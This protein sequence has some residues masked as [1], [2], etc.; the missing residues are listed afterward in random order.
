[1]INCKIK[2]EKELDLD[3]IETLTNKLEK[4]N[5]NILLL[6]QGQEANCKS[7]INLLAIGISY[8]KVLEFK[9]SGNDEQ[10]VKTYIEEYLGSLN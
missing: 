8:L 2:L 4:F 6:H 7:L 3:H 5:S 9:I 1:M 10:A